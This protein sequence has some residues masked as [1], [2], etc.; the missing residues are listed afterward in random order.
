VPGVWIALLQQIAVDEITRVISLATAPA[1]LLGAVA[2]LLSLLLGRLDRLSDHMRSFGQTGELTPV[3]LNELR[4][5]K[6]R[7]RLTRFAI[8]GCIH[9]GVITGGMVV[10]VFVD[11]LFGFQNSRTIVI[12]FI[13][14]MNLFVVALL[15][16][17]FDVRLSVST[18][19]RQ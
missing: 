16:L 12:M 8:T 13:V 17:W 19:R 9:C 15:F 11:A 2:G 3:Q 1:C 7:S 10:L 5:I 18:E 4:N 6:R 14:A